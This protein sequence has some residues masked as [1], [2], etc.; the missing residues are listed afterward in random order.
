MNARIHTIGVMRDAMRRISHAEGKALFP[1]E[2]SNEGG[3]KAQLHRTAQGKAQRRPGFL[4]A[5][6]RADIRAL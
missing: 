4:I 1:N 2:L 3:L 5:C 6:Q